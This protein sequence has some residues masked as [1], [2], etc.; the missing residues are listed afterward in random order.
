MR[1]VVVLGD[2]YHAAVFDSVGNLGYVVYGE[3]SLDSLRK[4]CKELGYVLME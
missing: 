1:C 4:K 3:S 2:G